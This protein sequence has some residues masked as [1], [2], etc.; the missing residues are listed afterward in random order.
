MSSPDAAAEFRGLMKCSTEKKTELASS[1]PV[2]DMERCSRPRNAPRKMHSSMKPT[3][4]AVKITFGNSPRRRSPAGRRMTPPNADTQSDITAMSATAAKKPNASR[5]AHRV[6]Q[7]SPSSARDFTFS[8]RVSG[9]SRRI[10]T[11]STMRLKYRWNPC[12]VTLGKKPRS[13]SV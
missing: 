2:R 8:D 7:R 10:A 5:D 11:I 4:I 3:H 6:S 12:P 13:A 1:A 9:H